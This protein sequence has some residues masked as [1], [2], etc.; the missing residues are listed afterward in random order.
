LNGCNSEVSAS[1]ETKVSSQILYM[2]ET[3][4]AKN[5]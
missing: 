2:D 5:P 4:S 3:G 1:K